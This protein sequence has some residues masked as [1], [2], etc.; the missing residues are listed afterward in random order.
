MHP[1]PADAFEAAHT[2]WQLHDGDEI[3]APQVMGEHLREETTIT[4]YLR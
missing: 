1:K 2:A 4:W 3:T